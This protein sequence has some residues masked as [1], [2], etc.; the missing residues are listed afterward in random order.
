MGLGPSGG[1]EE[2]LPEPRIGSAEV[3]QQIPD[4]FP[5]GEAQ[6]RLPAPMT[7][8]SVANALSVIVIVRSPAGLPVG[9]CLPSVD[10]LFAG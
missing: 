9:S 4:R 3:L 6:R 1:V 2:V 5:R 10:D 7:S 8:L